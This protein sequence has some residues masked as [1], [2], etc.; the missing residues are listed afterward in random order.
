MS[1]THNDPNSG[2]PNA[3]SLATQPSPEQQPALG[4]Q[5]AGVEQPAGLEQHAPAQYVQGYQRPDQPAQPHIEYIDPRDYVRLPRRSG[6]LRRLAIVGVILVFAGV[7]AAG[8]VDDWA[9]GQVEPAGPVGGQIEFLIAEGEGTNTTA[10]NLAAADVISNPTVFRY[11]L[12]CPSAAKSLLNCEDAQE[13]AWQAGKYR[14]NTDMSFQAVVDTLNEGSIPP[15]DFSVTIP[16]GLTVDQIIDRLVAENSKYNA[17][18]FRRELDNLQVET[19][20]LPED[21]Q[22]RSAADGFRTPYEGLLFP[23]TYQV[24]EDAA[25]SELSILRN[26]AFTMEGQFEIAINEAGGTLPPEAGPD[27]LNLTEYDMIIIASLIEEEAKIDADR[28]KIARVIYNRLLQGEALGIDASTRYAVNKRPGDPLLESELASESPFNTRNLNNVGLP[29]TPIA[30]P[31]L[32]SLRAA[33]APEEGDWFWYVLT[34]EGG[35]AGAHTFA[36]TGSEFEAAKA[37]C[38]DLGYC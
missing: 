32:A 27:Q 1:N 4:E 18:D 29:P 24:A 12:R 37:I 13:V 14:L 34:D 17:E 33:L 8:K 23:S 36:V 28:P 25:Q 7:W 22:I 30:A 21:L 38:Q 26:M 19:N 35:V 2:T 20:F 3:G 10:Q 5:P 31:G 16:E 15:E 6:P 9:A 11:W